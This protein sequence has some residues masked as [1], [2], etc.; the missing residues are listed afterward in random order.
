MILALK[1]PIYVLI[2]SIIKNAS[3]NLKTTVNCLLT[4]GFVIPCILIPGY[5]YN[6]YVDILISLSVI[7]LY[8]FVLLLTL[9]VVVVA[10]NSYAEYD[11]KHSFYFN[12]FIP[13]LEQYFIATV[14]P[15]MYFLFINKYAIED[16]LPIFIVGL[17]LEVLLSYQRHLF[18]SHIYAN[19]YKVG[20]NSLSQL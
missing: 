18:S 5:R 2:H 12:L 3:Q 9:S 11:V 15:M 6:D 16:L 20:F 10:Y 1:N 19:I 17:C 7:F 14:Y 4:A 8:S 13:A